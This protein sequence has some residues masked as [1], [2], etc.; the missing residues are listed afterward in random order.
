MRL[1]LF[2]GTTITE[3]MARVRTELGAEAL[4]LATRRVGDGVEITAALEP[5][6]DLPPPPR[7]DR[8]PPNAAALARL[9]WHGVPEALGHQLAQGDLTHALARSLT[10]AALP[11]DQHPLLVVGPPGAG[12]T[13]TIARLATRLVMA[14][15]TPMVITADGSRAGATE[16]LASFTRLLGVNLVVASH[17]VALARAFALRP[18]N[19]PVLID[20]PGIDPFN[21]TAQL[22]LAELKATCNAVVALVLAAGCDPAESADIAHAFRTTGATHMIATKLD[23]ARRLG[24]PIAAAAAGKLFLAEAGIGDGAANGLV[25]LTP[26][27]LAERLNRSA[28]P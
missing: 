20:A 19:T 6:E 2:R 27:L 5:E 10:F 3:A 4:I 15:T 8:P 28:I 17:P 13:L 23:I 25:P 9:A 14:G 11:L 24:G 12:K 21:P 16:Q 7:Q 26:A 18:E 1:K 22:E